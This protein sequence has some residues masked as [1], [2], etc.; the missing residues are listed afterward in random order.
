MFHFSNYCVHALHTQ[1][2]KMANTPRLVGTRFLDV[3]AKKSR[4]NAFKS[5]KDYP[6]PGKVAYLKIL[7]RQRYLSVAP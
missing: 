2:I 7:F 3:P 4:I 1:D 6:F 5:F